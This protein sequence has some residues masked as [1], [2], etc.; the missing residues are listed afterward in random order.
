MASVRIFCSV[1]RLGVDQPQHDVDVVDHQVHHD[2]VLLDPRHEGAKP[3][4]LDEDRP[5]HDVADLLHGAVEALDVPD[6]QDGRARARD[7]EQLARLFQG[8]RHRLLDEHAHARLEQVLRHR[9]VRV[10]GHG[11]ARHVDPPDQL[12][13]VRERERVVLGGHAPRALEV[14][15]DDADEVDVPQLGVDERVVLPHVARSHDRRAYPL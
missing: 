7:P 1:A 11:H 12:P 13:V 9:E 2:G 3:S 8:R 15:V 14:G 5:V 4:R 6:V 10:G